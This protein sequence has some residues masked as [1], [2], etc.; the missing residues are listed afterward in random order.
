MNEWCLGSSPS[1]PD[2]VRLKNR[3]FVTPWSTARLKERTCT[4]IH[5]ECFSSC[6]IF[7][8]MDWWGVTL[9]PATSE[10]C[11]SCFVLYLTL[12]FLPVPFDTAHSTWFPYLFYVTLYHSL[13]FPT[14][15]SCYAFPSNLFPYLFY[16]ALFHPLYFPTLVSCYAFPSTSFPYL[17]YVTLFHPLYF[18]TLVSCYAFP[19]NLFPYLFY[20]TLFLPLYLPTLISCY[21]FTQHISSV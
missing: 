20:V 10:S 3:P 19:S 11:L 14:L 9:V 6:D 5:L 4:C 2:A 13:Y 1:G 15:V 12:H 7:K 8:F 21:T 16:V 17:F 18:P